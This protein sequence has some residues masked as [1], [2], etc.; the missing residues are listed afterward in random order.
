M[1]TNPL[2]KTVMLEGKGRD[3]QEQAQQAVTAEFMD[4]TMFPNYRLMVN[5]GTGV[6]KGKAAIETTCEFHNKVAKTNRTIIG[7]HTVKQRD[8]MWPKEIAKWGRMHPFTGNVE[9]HCYKSLINIRG[10]HFGMAV[11]DEFHHITEDI[12]NF[13][14]YNTF[15]G[16]LLLTATEPASP[17]KRRIIERITNGRRIVL[18]ADQAID[19]QIINDFEVNVM[20]INLNNTEKFKMFKTNN[21]LY[22]DHIGYLKKCALVS[23]AKGSGNQERIRFALIDRI[24]YI[25]NSKSKTMAAAY[26]QKQ[27]QKKNERFIT[28]CA[29]IEQTEKLSIYTFHSKT[30][31]RWYKEFIANRIDHLVSVDMIRE[32]ENFDNLGRCLLIQVQRDPGKFD[33]LAGRTLRLPIGQLSKMIVIGAKGTQDE[34]SI[35]KALIHVNPSRIHHY[36]LSEDKYWPQNEHLTL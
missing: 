16:I 33:Q 20:W 8:N 11:M 34:N 29:S 25:G 26:I 3:A 27:F 21:T 6:G 22:T 19:A 36:Y 12:Y 15:D 10:Q 9:I 18:N 13:F 17:G 23:Q 24:R 28:V 1:K 5:Y 31:D 30:N 2:V 4:T 14:I 7:C 35:E 32:G